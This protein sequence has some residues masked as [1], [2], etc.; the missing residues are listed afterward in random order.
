MIPGFRTVVCQEQFASGCD[1]SNVHT[2]ITIKIGYSAGYE[3][4]QVFS[5]CSCKAACSCLAKHFAVN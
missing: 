3:L 5:S 4:G 2:Q 1:S